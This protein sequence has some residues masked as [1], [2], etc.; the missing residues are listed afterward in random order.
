MRFCVRGQRR[1]PMADNPYQRRFVPADKRRACTELLLQTIALLDNGIFDGLVV[2][3]DPSLESLTPRVIAFAAEHWLPTM[4][5][6]SSAV[7]YGGLMSYSIDFFEMWRRA[8]VYVDRILKGASPAELP[9]EQATTVALKI[10]VKTA[11]A[12]GLSISP[13]FLARADEVIE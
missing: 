9:V 10:N 1:K 12:L 5:P 2:T 7:Q 6:F 3:T 11:T 13:S 8:A 4:Y